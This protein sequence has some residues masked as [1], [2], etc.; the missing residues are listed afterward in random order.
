MTK[1]PLQP[2]PLRSN[3]R[4]GAMDEVIERLLAVV[5]ESGLRRKKVA[6]DAG[7]RPGKLSKIL[8]GHQAPTV[9]DFIAIA[10][11][12]GRDPAHLLSEKDV[13][14]G[15]DTL[16]A[17]HTAVQMVEQSLR[18]MIP[19][20]PRGRFAGAPLLP[21]PK[22]HAA[23]APIR[24]AA[25]SN[26]ELLAEV[27]EKKVAIPREAQNRGAKRVARAIGNSMEG[28]NGIR[29]GQLVFF[30]PT[31]SRRT[32]TGQ[33]VVCSVGEAVYIKRLEGT[34]RSATL[35]SINPDHGPVEVADANDIRIHGV[36]VHPA[37]G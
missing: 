26:A 34:G 23:G 7:M 13:V 4:A 29:D 11:A 31:R 35:H 9:S 20:A 5:K 16:R 14:V 15:L 6:H 2:L 10:R 1:Q 32:A 28:P 37:V 17:A 24:A 22:R 3:Y 27:E 8:N 33:V 25:N 12:V 19:Q 18:A 21:K 30:R 36:V